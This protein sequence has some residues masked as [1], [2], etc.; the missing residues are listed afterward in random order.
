MT[1]PF[2]LSKEWQIVRARV[3]RRD[4]F[5]CIFCGASKSS[6]TRLIVDHIQTYKSRPDLALEM[7]N[8]RTLC[9]ACDNR[10]HIEKMKTFVQ[11]TGPDGFPINPSDNWYKHK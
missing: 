2:Y 6:G 11:E 7:T 1:N 10:R 4:G 8:L 9:A 5:A 3:L